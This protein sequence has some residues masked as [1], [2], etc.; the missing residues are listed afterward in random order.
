MKLIALLTLTAL[1]IVPALAAEKV[2]PKKIDDPI[3]FD[4]PLVAPPAEKPKLNPL[5][6]DNSALLTSWLSGPQEQPCGV[7][8]PKCGKELLVNTKLQLT[9][10]PPARIVRCP[11]NDKC[12]FAT[13][14]F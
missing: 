12:K 5:T 2:E 14:V 6:Q 11:D 3:K 9:T 10:N 13:A 8:C 1:L 7:A 4:E